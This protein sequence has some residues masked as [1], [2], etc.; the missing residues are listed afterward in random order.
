[1][2]Q[3]SSYSLLFIALLLTA[4]LRLPVSGIS[5][6]NVDEAVSAVV[7]QEIA[8]G[9][10]PY[11][12]A[13]DHRGPL[14]YY[15]YALI[16][17][18]CGDWNMVAVHWMYVLI[19]G[20]IAGLLFGTSPKLGGIAAILF[21]VFSWTHSPMDMWAAH[22]EWL[23]ILGSSMAIM[24]LCRWK[25]RSVPLLF[26]GIFLG[27]ATLSK[28]VAVWDFAAVG[29]WLFWAQWQERMNWAIFL[30][31]GILVG[32]GFALPLIGMGMYFHTEGG[33]EDLLFYVWQYNVQYYL[34]EVSLLERIG[35]SMALLVSFF[36]DA[37][38]LTGLI[39]VGL[40][41]AWSRRKVLTLQE[42]LLLCWFVG[43]LLGGLTSGRN[44]G[45]YAIQWLP[46]SCMIAAWGGQR[47]VRYMRDKDQREGMMLMSGILGIGLLLPIG[48]TLVK[49]KVYLESAFHQD[50]QPA[51]YIREH[52]KPSD[53]LF[54]W[55]F[56]PEF[57]L[58]S[59]R[60]PATR[61]VYCNVLTGLIPW[62]NLSHSSTEYAVVPGTR[63]QLLKDLRRHPPAFVLDTSPADYNS[64]GKYP[65]HQY[66]ELAKWLQAH[67]DRD[68]LFAR[69][70]PH[71]Q[72]HLYRRHP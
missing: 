23:L 12:D 8:E 38:L 20:G 14:T 55:G 16:F 43:A 27:M 40:M 50:P 70:F 10:L 36:N 63:E 41:D 44:F 46:A 62:E 5:I 52:S 31:Q 26:A 60:R 42:K 13:I 4:L 2:T 64:Y 9:G 67:Y 71:A 48:H 15:A 17:E 21:V 47:L 59:Q 45:H 37:L 6:F 68:S 65:I 69:Q 66:P 53:R 54:V 19:L 11:R 32:V 28:Q 30:K 33:W 72:F 56:A 25:L 29:G 39:C 18:I 49:N 57:Y 7:A 3:R 34:P 51:P 35:S 58:Y 61:Y 22:T 24:I 1:M